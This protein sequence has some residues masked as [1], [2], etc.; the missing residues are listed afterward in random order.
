M[1]NKRY[2]I[3]FAGDTIAD[4]MVYKELSKAEKVMN[5][6]FSKFSCYVVHLPYDNEPLQEGESNE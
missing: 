4:Y 3:L 5:E 6:K 2:M 1:D